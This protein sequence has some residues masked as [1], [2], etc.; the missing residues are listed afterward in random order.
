MLKTE[1]SRYLGNALTDHHEK[2]WTV[3]VRRRCGFC[4]IP[5]ATCYRQHCTQHKAPVFKLLRG[6]FW[7]FFAP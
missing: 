5:L 4:Q 7:G 1:N 3:H 6:P 2:H